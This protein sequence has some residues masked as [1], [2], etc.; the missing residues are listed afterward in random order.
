MDN[1]KEIKK[2]SLQ[3]PEVSDD[4]LELIYEDAEESFKRLTHRE[5][6]TGYSAAVRAIAVIL[7]NRMGRE[8]ETSHGSGGVSIGYDDIPSAVKHML[9][10]PLAYVGG[11]KLENVET[12]PEE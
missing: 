2:L 7:Y 6:T 12:L 4:L 10:Y 1:A 8:G 9:P 11:R 5:S 3:L